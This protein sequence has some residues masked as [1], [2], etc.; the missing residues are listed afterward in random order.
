MA[1][2]AATHHSAQRGEWRDLHEAPRR[3]RTAS[4]EATYDALRSQTT[5]VAGDTDF[6]SLYEEELG[7]TR[8]DRLYEVCRRWRA[9][10]WRFA[11]SS[12]LLFPSRLS[13]CPRSPLPVSLAGAVCVS[14]SGRRKSWWKCR[15]SY[16]TPRCTGLW[17]RT[18]TFQFLMVVIASVA[19]FSVSTQDRVQQRLVEHGIFQQR[20]PS[21]SL[22]LLFRVVAEFFILH[23]RLPVCREWQIK[24]VF[25]TFPRGKKC[26]VGSAL[27]VGT[28]PRVEPIHA[29]GSAGGFLRGRSPSGVL[30]VLP[31]R[32]IIQWISMIFGNSINLCFAP[33]TS[34]RVSIERAIVSSPFARLADVR[35]AARNDPLCHRALKGLSWLCEWP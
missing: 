16:L 19:V 29:G 7:G 1:L 13:T 11:H 35:L 28:A 5:S 32:L 31:C 14:R 2:A 10:C 17:S 15:R 6:F 34:G 22:T 9:N 25:R 20:L 27:G 23:R 3:Q 18:L 33:C 8:P 30:L 21:R 12:I 26:D 4:A 24:G